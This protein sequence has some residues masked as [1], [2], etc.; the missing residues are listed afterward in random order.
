MVA[1]GRADCAALDAVCWALLGRHEP[2]LRAGL[3]VLCQT[4]LA[5]GLPLIAGPGW[6]EK[7]VAAM[8]AALDEALAD[9]ALAGPREALLLAGAET[10]PPTAYES[11]IDTP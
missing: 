3:A 5:P 6:S 7:D 11:L 9:P 10:L 1:D 2:D 8:R 4:P